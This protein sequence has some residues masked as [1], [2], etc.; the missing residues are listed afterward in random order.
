MDGRFV[1]A[2]GARG[3]ATRAGRDAELS[4][5]NL[6][7]RADRIPVTVGRRL[8]EPTSICDVLRASDK[9]EAAGARV[10]VTAAGFSECS[11]GRRAASVGRPHHRPSSDRARVFG[12]S[13]RTHRSRGQG[14][15]RGC[16]AEG[17][18]VVT[19][20]ESGR[21]QLF[22]VVPKALIA[23]AC[24]RQRALN[25]AAYQRSIGSSRPAGRDLEHAYSIVV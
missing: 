2:A 21:V 15:A 8:D 12:R 10:G 24:Q 4:R 11:L 14:V 7:N 9:E 6:S 19:R 16:V 3:E 18:S 13:S 5:W 22:A 17:A 25:C 20:D 23:Q 1:L